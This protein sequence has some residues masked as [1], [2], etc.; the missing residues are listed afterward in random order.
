MPK[1]VIFSSN[2]LH[3]TAIAFGCSSSFRWLRWRK[4]N[5]RGSEQNPEKAR[6][7]SGLYSPLWPLSHLQVNELT[8]CTSRWQGQEGRAMP[9][10]CG[11]LLSRCTC[12]GKCNALAASAPSPSPSATAI[13]FWKGVTNT[14]YRC[15]LLGGLQKYLLRI[16]YTPRRHQGRDSMPARH[17]TNN[18]N[19]FMC[20]L[21][22]S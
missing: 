22:R 9:A 7:I 4:K 8:L 13:S 11:C 3:L 5:R 2:H 19:I 17:A 16:A 12:P 18:K 20:V 10:I 1:Y 15:I 21:A 6:R 14:K